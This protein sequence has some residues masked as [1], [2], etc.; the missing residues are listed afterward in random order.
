MDSRH[1]NLFVGIPE[2]LPTELTSVLHSGVCRVERIVSRG[3]ASPPSFWYDQSEDE[4]VL[5]MQGE[6]RLEF[7]DGTQQGMKRGDW[8]M[9]PAH[10][11]HRVAW[12]SPDVDTIW[13]A[14][15][16]DLGPPK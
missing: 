11:R 3:H 15:F 2:E 10:K 16:I 9:L 13:L 1:G 7:A 6:A 4:F 14:V 12:T 5:V 8:C